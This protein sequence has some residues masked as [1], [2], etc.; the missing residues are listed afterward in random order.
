MLHIYIISA[1]YIQQICSIYTSHLLHVHIMDA[2]Y[3]HQ[4]CFI[5]T[6]YVLHRYIMYTSHMLNIYII[7]ASYIHHICFI[8][9]SHM[10]HIYI[11]YA[12]YIHHICFMYTPYPEAQSIS[13]RDTLRGTL[14]VSREGRTE[15]VRSDYDCPSRHHDFGKGARSEITMDYDA[16][17][18]I[19]M[20]DDDGQRWA[21]M[22]DGRLR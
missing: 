12:S 3:T 7:Y 21:M 4:R 13:G 22:D 9:T 15:W 2:S 6:S 20:H 18:C 19:T 5:Y 16:L 10:L 1:P 14:P 8:Y 11:I 17:R